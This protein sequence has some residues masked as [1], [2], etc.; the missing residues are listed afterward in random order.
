M[1]VDHDINENHLVMAVSCMDYR[2]NTIVNSGLNVY[3]NSRWK[4][5]LNSSGYYIFVSRNKITEDNIVINANSSEYI[6]IKQGIPYGEILSDFSESNTP[7]KPVTISFFLVPIFYAKNIFSKEKTC[8][9]GTIIAPSKVTKVK[10]ITHSCLI[11]EFFNIY[12]E[13]PE[14]NMDIKFGNNEKKTDENGITEFIYDNVDEDDLEK[15]DF[16]FFG[17]KMFIK[18][19]NNIEQELIVNSVDLKKTDKFIRDR[20]VVEFEKET[21]MQFLIKRDAL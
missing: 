8:L 3:F 16:E 13:R 12:D 4:A 17:E 14:V 15:K 9:R 21:I 20:C 6:S 11:D 1:I 2:K 18:L 10:I 19:N 5:I 7:N